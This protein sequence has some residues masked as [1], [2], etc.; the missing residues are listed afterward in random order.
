MRSL[1][2]KLSYSN[3][4]ATAA[5]FLA[6]GGISY[7]AVE[8]PRSSVG[9]RQLK[10]E[11]VST[12]K[13]KDGAITRAKVADG[14]VV[15]SKIADGAVTGTKVNL[16]TLG[17]VP[18]AAFATDADHAARSDHALSSSQ[19]D[20]AL[21]AKEAGYLAGQPASA[22]GAALV[23]HTEIPPTDVDAEWWAP[24][25]GASQAGSTLKSV[26]MLTPSTTPSFARGFTSFSWTGP[27]PGDAANVR[28]QLYYDEEPVLGDLS[29]TR[30]SYYNWS[31]SYSVEIQA[32]GRLA[33]K[34]TEEVNGEEI[35]AIS[36]QT[37]LLLSPGP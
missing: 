12:A 22:Y 19:A 4:V 23:A 2:R 11:A 20:F 25:S 37:A 29:L 31:P 14:A 6:L 28:V 35:P 27:S 8:L 9:T 36:L 1:H 32:G 5:L 21:K 10:N 26:E 3:V 24:V 17:R 34:V 15:N 7:A 16:S 33:I 18:N 13:T 30:L